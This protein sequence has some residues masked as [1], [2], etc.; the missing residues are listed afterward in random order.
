[1]YYGTRKVLIRLDAIRMR[2]LHDA[3][4]DELAARMVI[5]LALVAMR[6]D[7]AMRIIMHWEQDGRT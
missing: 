3:G 4:I 5:N 7:I 6:R 1:M 2:F